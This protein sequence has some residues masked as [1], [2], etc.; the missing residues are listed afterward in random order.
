MYTV[1]KIIVPIWRAIMESKYTNWFLRNIKNYKRDT[2]II[3]LF[4]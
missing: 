3:K 2:S 4:S 1:E